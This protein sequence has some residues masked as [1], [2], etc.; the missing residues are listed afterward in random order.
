MANASASRA[1]HSSHARAAFI[2]DTGAS[3]PT[4]ITSPG[5][6]STL[7]ASPGAVITTFAA[8]SARMWR[9]SSGERRNTIGT[10]T[11]PALRMPV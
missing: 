8:E 10:I 6:P 7:S 9:T 2:V 5:Q 11:A 4:R 1:S 3:P